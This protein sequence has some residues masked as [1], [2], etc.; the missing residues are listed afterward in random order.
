MRPL[1][2]GGVKQLFHNLGNANS[3]IEFDLIGTTSNRGSIGS[4]LYLIAGGVTPY[5]EQNGDYHRWSQNLMRV[6]VGLAANTLVD[7]TTVLW[8]DNSSTTYT[9]LAGD[10][11]CQVK[12]NGT[13]TQIH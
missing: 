2:T 6:D 11:T 13:Y 8:P 9:G 10:H 7:T 3:W 12:Q 1:N 5:R 4:K